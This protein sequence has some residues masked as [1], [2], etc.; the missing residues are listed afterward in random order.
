MNIKA[1]KGSQMGKA[2]V[3]WVKIRLSVEPRDFWVGLFFDKWRRER[4]LYVQR[5]YIN[6]IPFIPIIIERWSV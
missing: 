2:K 5:T 3:S 6:V 1:R 4:N